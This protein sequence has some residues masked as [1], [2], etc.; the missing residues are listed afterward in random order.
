MLFASRRDRSFGAMLAIGML[1]V[2]GSAVGIRAESGFPA[3]SEFEILNGDG[4]AV[5]GYA[6]YEFRSDGP[7]SYVLH[8]ENRFLDGQYDIEHDRLTGEGDRLAVTSYRHDYLNKDGSL[9]RE[10]QADFRTGMASCVV[11]VDGH[12]Q[13]SSAKLEF[14]PDTYSG[15]TVLVPLTRHLRH[16]FEGPILFHNF[17]CIPGPT[18]LSIKAYPPSVATWKHHAGQLVEVRIKPD[19]GWLDLL[20]APFVPRMDAWF[21]PSQDW[22]YVGGKSG[23]FYQGPE[24]ILVQIPKKPRGAR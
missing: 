7:G 12:P 16:G 9:Q 21:E 2:L 22:A 5:V 19:F 15:S 14:P 11:Y 6:R 10:A 13:V 17:N 4:S 23:R 18:I 3:S 24:I 1:S 20:I 8:G